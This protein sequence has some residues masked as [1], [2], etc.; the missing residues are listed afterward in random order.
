MSELGPLKTLSTAVKILSIY[1]DEV[2]WFSHVFTDV[3]QSAPVIVR[4]FVKRGSV[5]F[6]RVEKTSSTAVATIAA[7]FTTFVAYFATAS[8]AFSGM[9]AMRPTPSPAYTIAT[10]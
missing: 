1:D 10:I 3:F 5:T 7:Y 9:L 8:N 6:S 2:I 4:K